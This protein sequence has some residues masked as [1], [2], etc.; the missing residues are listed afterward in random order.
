ML[1]SV[2]F[3]KNNPIKD[4]SGKDTHFINAKSED[5]AL[6]QVVSRLVKDKGPLKYK[7]KRNGP[8]EEFGASRVGLLIWLLR[9]NKDYLVKEEEDTR[10]KNPPPD[11]DDWKAEGVKLMKKMPKDK[12]EDKQMNLFDKQASIRIAKE[13]DKVAEYLASEGLTKYAEQLDEVSNTLE[14]VF[15]EEDP[16]EVP[17]K[18]GL[19]ALVEEL[20]KDLSLEYSAA[21]QYIQHAAKLNGAEFDAIRQEIL[22]HAD[23]EI[24]HAK[25]ISDKI[26]YL[27]YE[28]TTAMSPAVSADTSEEMLV[29]DLKAE[30]EAIARYKV[31]ID[32]ATSLGEHGLRAMLV[33]I[34]SDE[35][36]HE[37]DL[38]NTL[39]MENRTSPI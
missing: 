21:I 7:A 32:Q 13:L 38:L 27:G 2:K 19:D 17:Q 26:A 15:P 1:F 23:E 10:G 33:E 28:P 30:K 16:P 24:H 3:P 14:L 18:S 9:E 6:A 11:K 36:E 20:N 39:G 37:N 8:A 25:L 34:L 12:E 29:Q 5:Q 22:D 35:E 4:S 31:R